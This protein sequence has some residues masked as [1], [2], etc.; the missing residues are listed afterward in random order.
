MKF[1]LFYQL[2]AA[3]TQD[4]AERYR[5]LMAEAIEADRLGF[6]TLWLAE[7]HFSPRF[8]TLPVPTLQLAAI[9]ERTTRLRLGIAVHLLPLH[10]PVRLAEEIATLDV[11]SGGRVEFG[12]GRGAFP[13]NY[14]GF[15]VDMGTSRERFEEMLALVRSAWSDERLTFHGRFYELD[16]I[17]VFPKPAQRPSPPIRLAANSPDTFRFAGANGY[18]IFAGG[19]VNPI[20]VLPERLAIYHRALAEARLSLPSDWLAALF[21]TFVGQSREAVRATI[22]QSLINYFRTVSEMIRPESIAVPEDYERVVERTRSMRYE[23][24][25]SL[26]AV[27]GEPERCVHRIAALREQFGFTRM[28]CWF[29]TGGL[30][31]HRNVIE[32]MR[33]FAEHVMP[34]FK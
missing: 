16:D 9:A 3:A 30:S 6:D 28:V 34:H 26:M 25:E 1:D 27:F 23:T 10:H 32:A 20:N 15:G 21:L 17:E 7:I 33:L 13:N 29:E 24:V 8:C 18:P 31:G 11:L 2:P 4:P 19:P 22:E 14:H 12:A 5:E